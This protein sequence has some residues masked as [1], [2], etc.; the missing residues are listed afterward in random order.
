[1]STR[2][3]LL[4]AAASLVSAAPLPIGDR[5]VPQCTQ[6]SPLLTGNGTSVGTCGHP[7]LPCPSGSDIDFKLCKD[8]CV[9][10]DPLNDESVS[11]NLEYNNH[12]AKCTLVYTPQEAEADGRRML[13]GASRAKEEAQFASFV[14]EVSSKRVRQE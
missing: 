14:S 6:I 8:R 4:S 9:T 3:A 10:I 1:M 2:A 7:S 11:G 12:T 5:I 13:Q